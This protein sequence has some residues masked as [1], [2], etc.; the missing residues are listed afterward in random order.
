MAERSG[1]I[2]ALGEWVLRRA[3]LEALSWPRV[4]VAVNVSPKQLRQ[5]DFTDIVQKILLQ[6][7]LEPSRLELELTEGILIYD[8]ED[9]LAKIGKLK[10]LG[11]RL[12]LDDFGTGYS[13]LKLFAFAAFRQA[14][15]R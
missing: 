2:H 7:G 1:D 9:A 8:R 5:P 14:E 4:S 11:V 13:S 10:E 15:D 3:C 6:T 12:A